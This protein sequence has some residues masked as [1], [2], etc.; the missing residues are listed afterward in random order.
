MKVIADQELE[1]TVLQMDGHHFEN[2]T[3]TQCVLV[4]SGGD[5]SWTNCKF[6]N[7]QIRFVGAAGKTINFLK[8]FGMV[9]QAPKTAEAA[10][11]SSV[12]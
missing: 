11:S 2:C 3:I 6:V 4:F 5:F 1:S 10:G 12:H 8:H 7:C 9:P